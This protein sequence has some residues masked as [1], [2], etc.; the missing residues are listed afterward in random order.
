M[1][2]PFKTKVVTPDL[3]KI[4]TIDDNDKCSLSGIIDKMQCCGNKRSVPEV[5]ARYRN[6]SEEFGYIY[7]NV[8]IRLLYNLR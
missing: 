5:F 6:W 2:L 1:L 8:F 7:L 3:P 4:L